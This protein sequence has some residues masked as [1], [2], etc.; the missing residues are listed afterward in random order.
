ML[1]L[2]KIIEINGELIQKSD[3]IYTVKKGGVL[4][5]QF[6]AP[7]KY[8]FGT[9][10]DTFWVNIGVL[11]FMSICF[12]ITLYFDVFRKGM[13]WMGARLARYIK[14]KR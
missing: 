2:D 5:A 12:M 8:F 1:T 10:C 7:Q 11:W 6:Y 14:P 4:D 9:R 3:P 13:D